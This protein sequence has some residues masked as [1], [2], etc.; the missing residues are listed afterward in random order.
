MGNKKI[1]LPI[2]ITF[3]FICIIVYLFTNIKQSKVICEK[4]ETFD[5]D[6]KVDETIVSIIDG[7]KISSLF[8]RKKI[9]LPDKFSRNEENFNLVK[10]SLK[11]TLD[12]L[13]NDVTYSFNENSVIVNIEASHN[14]LIL[15]D[16]I[17]L[18]DNNGELSIAV[19]PNTKSSNVV[20][21][22]VGDNYT[23]GEL[24][25]KFKNNE[26]YCK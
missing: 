26:Y 25:K 2:I 21:L 23:D 11:H 17:E 3:I 9:T 18:F 24:K 15:L 10:N 19:D 1:R 14:E 6:I 12:Y 22:K 5:S 16:N 20:T 13:G 8:V 7:K 4:S